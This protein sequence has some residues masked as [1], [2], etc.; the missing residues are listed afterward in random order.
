MDIFYAMSESVK[1]RRISY[2]WGFIPAGKTYSYIVPLAWGFEKEWQI[3]ARDS[4]GSH[5]WGAGAKMIWVA[6]PEGET[7]QQSS[8]EKSEFH[9]HSHANGPALITDKCANV[10]KVRYVRTDRIRLGR[11]QVIHRWTDG[12]AVVKPSSR[13][14]IPEGPKPNIA[15]VA[16]PEESRREVE[17][18]LDRYFRRT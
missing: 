12:S 13:A 1:G 2:G 10:E 16:T 14:V 5:Q 17:R 15:R 3:H 6:L 4:S 18:I 7:L 9:I 8:E 11:S